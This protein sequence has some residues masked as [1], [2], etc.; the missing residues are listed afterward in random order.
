MIRPRPDLKGVLPLAA[1][2]TL[3]AASLFAAVGLCAVTKRPADYPPN[4][5]SPPAKPAANTLGDLDAPVSIVIY[6]DLECPFSAAMFP[7]VHQLVQSDSKH[8]HLTVKQF[9]LPIHPH[10]TLAAEAVEAA[11]AQ[12]KYFTMAEL[13]QANPR[14]M[15]RDQYLHYAAL[16]HLDVPTFAH[17]LD[18]HRYFEKIR[19]DLAEGRAL[20]IDSTPTLLINGHVL[21]GSQRPKD[22]TEIL[23]TSLAEASENKAELAADAGLELPPVQMADLVRNPTATRGPA[24]APVTIVEFTDFQCPFCRRA[25]TPLGQFLAESGT[26]VRYVFRNFPLDF[27]EHAELAAEAALAARAQGRFWEMHD[28]LFANQQ[29]LSRQGLINLA[30]QIHLDMGR[31]TNDLDSGKYRAEIGA[32]RALGVQAD[33]NGTPAFFI[34]GRRIDGAL[35]LPELNQ[36]VALAVQNAPHGIQA[37]ADTGVTRTANRIAGAKDAPVTLTWFSDLQTSSALRMGQ[38][39][40]QILKASTDEASTPAG[41]DS[42]A[43]ASGHIKSKVRVLFKLYA[44]PGHTAAPLAHLALVAAAAQG[45]FWPLYDV[46][47]TLHFTGEATQDRAAILAAAKSAG[48]DPA[49]IDSAMNAGLDAP[50]LR[51]DTAEAEWRGVRGAPTLYINDVRVDGIQSPALYAGYIKKALQA[52][53]T[54]RAADTPPALVPPVAA[55]R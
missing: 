10:A 36:A 9:P 51:A 6:T 33:V 30:S 15:D 3:L 39:V 55:L 34:N 43:Q 47:A 12:G 22:L 11:G 46:I 49:S 7:V 53:D 8:I 16:L 29:D 13:I 1:F 26:P 17:D 42:G 54:A 31:F 35:S 18:S 27:H 32:D 5:A 24:D 28:L 41:S 40:R 44:L 52:A 19:G 45:H 50:D 38:L 25:A 37:T 20:G 23:R 2:S 48:F 14:Q 4:P 21:S